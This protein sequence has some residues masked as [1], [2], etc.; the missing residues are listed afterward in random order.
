MNANVGM[1]FPVA[2]K[3]NSYTA[4][5]APSYATGKSI[6]EAVSASVSFD[7]ADG[8]FY[9]DDALL[10]SDNSVMG[11]SISFEPSGLTDEA[12]EL[13]LGEVKA[14]TEYSLT[15]D[16]APDVG[17][18]YVRVMRNKGTVSYEGWWFYKLKFGVSSE[19]TRT[20]E[21]SIEWRVP[22]LEGTGSAVQLTS[23]GKQTYYVHQTFSTEA[24]AKT[25]L[26]GKAGGMS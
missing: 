17:F 25:W 7:R 14:T 3:I 9:G 10:D 12:R 2:A 20:K 1:L 8:Q 16:A 11:Y 4:G 24:A 26:K 21:R 22:T 23:G 19:E 18:G 5:S 6:G 15:A 13:L